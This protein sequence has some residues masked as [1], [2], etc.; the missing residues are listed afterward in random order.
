MLRSTVWK[1]HL[2]R[3]LALIE[4]TF[5]SN[6]LTRTQ[7]TIGGSLLTMQNK[8]SLY[9]KNITTTHCFSNLTFYS[10]KATSVSVITTT[11][12]LSE[13][14]PSHL[15]LIFEARPVHFKIWD[16]FM[17]HDLSTNKHLNHY[18]RL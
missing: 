5:N 18:Y 16:G 8:R 11:H 13:K 7:Q 17:N 6:S 1:Q 9:Q 14:K 10:R 12:L 3:L 4:S 15:P 2:K